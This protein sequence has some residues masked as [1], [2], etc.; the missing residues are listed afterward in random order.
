MLVSLLNRMQLS[1]IAK[2]GRNAEAFSIQL[3]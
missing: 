3:V 1:S 2:S